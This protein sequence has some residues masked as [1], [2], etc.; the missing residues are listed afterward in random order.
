MKYFRSII[1]FTLLLL[2][3]C[4]HVNAQLYF[5]EDMVKVSGQ[6]VD[7][8]NGENIAYAQVVNLR[9]HGSTMTDTKGN[10]SIQAD[11]SDTLTIRLLG[12]RDKIISVKDV[13]N[14]AKE[15]AKITLIPIRFAID[16]VEVEGHTNGMN[17]NG[18][19]KGKSSTIPSELRSE[20]FN[21]K[22]GILTAI[23]NPI[24]FLHYNLSSGEKEK[25]TALAAIHSERQWQILSL[26]YNKDV[27]QRITFLTGDKLDDFMVYC[28]AYHGLQANATTYEVEKRIKELYAEYLKLH[29]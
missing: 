2:G 22:P 26:I 24:S 13:L 18:I 14:K 25:R 1:L 5:P 11:P 23:T 9:V 15:N 27:V 8:S 19:P 16:Q 6:L 20:D 21:S 7:E 12:Y 4:L 29:P 10:F 17:L 28:N 3:Y